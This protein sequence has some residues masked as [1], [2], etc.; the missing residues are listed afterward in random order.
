MLLFTEQQPTTDH[1]ND[2][3]ELDTLTR[4][5]RRPRLELL[6]A[7][8]NASHTPEAQ[9]HAAAARA[10]AEEAELDALVHRFF[11]SAKTNLL[12]SSCTSHQSVY[13]YAAN[14][15]TTTLLYFCRLRRARTRRRGAVT[16][17]PRGLGARRG[18]RCAEP[19]YYS[20]PD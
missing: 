10:A 12:S 17:S 11:L 9:R 15:C 4:S 2:P 3:N 8:S 19:I 7:T 16:S 13:Y 5:I 1:T 14:Y 18:T 20:D 6:I